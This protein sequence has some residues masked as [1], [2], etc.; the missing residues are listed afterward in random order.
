[1]L[2][3]EAGHFGFVAQQIFDGTVWKEDSADFVFQFTQS[4]RFVAQLLN[5]DTELWTG[6]KIQ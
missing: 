5:Q 3:N 6:L 1:V 2:F 4:I